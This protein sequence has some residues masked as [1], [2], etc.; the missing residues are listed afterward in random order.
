[1]EEELTLKAA[2]I[3]EKQETIIVIEKNKKL[4][5]KNLSTKRNKTLTVEN[6]IENHFNINPILLIQI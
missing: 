3:I 5:K 4:I 1:M 6:I 2:I